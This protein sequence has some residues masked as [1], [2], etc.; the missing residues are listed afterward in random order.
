MEV[1]SAKVS[2][3][4]NKFLDSH[5]NGVLVNVGTNSILHSFNNSFSNISGVLPIVL[6]HS[7][8]QAFFRQD[9]FYSNHYYGDYMYY[10]GAVSIGAKAFFD[11]CEFF[12]NSVRSNGGA[13]ASGGNITIVNSVFEQNNCVFNGGSIYVYG[14]EAYIIDTVFIANRA[15]YGGAIYSG[16]ILA[17]ATVPLRVFIENCTMISNYATYYGGAIFTNSNKSILYNFIH[18]FTIL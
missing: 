18:C 5:R 11:S 13:I 2:L 8:S 4:S 6:T 3:T 10:G 9:Q 16:G 12:N 7:N 1:R 17:E 14:G 15:Q